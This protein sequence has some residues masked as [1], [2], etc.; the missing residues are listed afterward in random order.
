MPFIFFQWHAHCL[1][2]K[3]RPEFRSQVGGFMTMGQ[4]SS[5]QGHHTALRVQAQVMPKGLGDFLFP[6]QAELPN[7]SFSSNPDKAPLP[8]QRPPDKVTHSCPWEL[9]AEFCLKCILYGKHRTPFGLSSRYISVCPTLH[10][11]ASGGG[12]RRQNEA[13]LLTV[14]RR[15]SQG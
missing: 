12:G 9:R 6:H 3:K 10:S 7:I 8:H 15:L 4:W 1:P 5:G 11:P 2:S 14:S 13:A